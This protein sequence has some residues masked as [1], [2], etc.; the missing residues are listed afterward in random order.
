MRA[1]VYQ[2]NYITTANGFLQLFCNFYGKILQKCDKNS[3]VLHST[4]D[5]LSKKSV[6][7]KIGMIASCVFFYDVILSEA[8]NL[9]SI[10]SGKIPTVA[11]LPRND[12]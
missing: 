2:L 8:K 1:I 9:R 7:V 12:K 3:G 5:R 11:L 6:T 10:E 4:P